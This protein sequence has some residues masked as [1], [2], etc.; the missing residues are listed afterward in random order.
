M[1]E[2]LLPQGKDGLAGPAG[3][4]NQ[5]PSILLALREKAMLPAP[6]VL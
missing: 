5:D 6:H 4:E 1:P 2:V 3:A